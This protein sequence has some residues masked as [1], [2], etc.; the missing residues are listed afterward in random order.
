MWNDREE[1]SDCPLLSLHDMTIRY[2]AL[3][4]P[5][6]NQVSNLVSQ[7]VRPLPYGYS[8]KPTLQNDSVC[9]LHCIN[10][11]DR[12]VHLASDQLAAIQERV[13]PMVR[14]EVRAMKAMKGR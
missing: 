7:E 4:R 14:I 6:V 8:D 10:M 3:Y 1:Q 9:G 12:Y 2:Q 5:G 13:S 11:T